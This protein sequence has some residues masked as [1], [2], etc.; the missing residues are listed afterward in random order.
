MTLYHV[1]A[2]AIVILFSANSAIVAVA[3]AFFKRLMSRPSAQVKRAGALCARSGAMAGST[4][5][6]CLQGID[7]TRREV[8][9]YKCGHKCHKGCE[10]DYAV[11]QNL[12]YDTG[13]NND[14]WLGCPQCKM[15]LP[16]CLDLEQ[17]AEAAGAV[18]EDDDRKQHEE[19]A[20]VDALAEA[21]GAEG[22][23][24]KED[25]RAATADREAAGALAESDGLKEGAGKV[26]RG[27]R[28]LKGPEELGSVK[29]PCDNCGGL[30]APASVKVKS[31]RSQTFQC[32]GCK[33][34]LSSSFFY[35]PTHSTGPVA[36]KRSRG[37][38][39]ARARPAA[40]PAASLS[41]RALGL[42]LARQ[43]VQPRPARSRRRSRAASPGARPSCRRRALHA[44]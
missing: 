13:N 32:S 35:S 40:H 5:C 24:L 1:V 7:F 6:L 21:L 18:A 3:S 44:P 23:G 25:A 15:D 39:R 36:G 20:F 27:L 38:G 9:I 22:D 41:G 8:K 29:L 37:S 28:G 16:A 26:S 12:K 43:R 11:H 42:D 10:A 4:C 31:K 17:Q 30:F 19:E 33:V 34:K 14:E 2:H